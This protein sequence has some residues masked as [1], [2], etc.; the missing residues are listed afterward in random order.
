MPESG[1]GE[2]PRCPVCDGEVNGWQVRPDARDGNYY[3]CPRCGKYLISRTALVCLDRL[4][5]EAL[6]ALSRLISK[7]Q[8]DD[9]PFQ[10]YTTQLDAAEKASIPEAAKSANEGATTGESPE[11]RPTV[12]AASTLNAAMELEK[13]RQEAISALASVS[14]TLQVNRFVDLMRKVDEQNDRLVRQIAS[15][16]SSILGSPVM[17]AISRL[18]SALPNLLSMKIAAGPALLSMK[19]PSIKVSSF[20]VTEMRRTATLAQSLAA[21]IDWGKMKAFELAVQTSLDPL[22]T[23]FERYSET[24]G[25]LFASYG[26]DLPN[27]L[28]DLEVPRLSVLDY[29]RTVEAVGLVV[30]IEEDSAVEEYREE[31]RQAPLLEEP[32]AIDR[33]LLGLKPALA[34]AWQGAKAA[35]SADT[36]DSL[37]HACVSL[38]ELLTHVLHRCAPDDRIGAWPDVSPEDFHEGRPTRRGRFR[39]LCRAA[40]ARDRL[41]ALFDAD[42]DCFIKIMD[43]LESGTHGM[44]AT[45]EKEDVHVLIAKIEVLLVLMIKVSNRGN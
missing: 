8:E 24:F 33:L 41:T 23:S 10:V 36:P 31:L 32:D 39:Y 30:P 14:E 44:P 16:Q 26:Q 18:E 45:L 40:L 19:L 34:T 3:D 4:G 17:H 13:R 28:A 12:S 22:R 20:L 6:A 25:S 27:A 5:G 35:L 11:S 42:A 1:A 29:H 2:S 43:L 38:R 15:F 21:S 37:R 7:N 9:H